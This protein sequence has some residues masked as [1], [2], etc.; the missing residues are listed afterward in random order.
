[1]INQ[2]REVYTGKL[3][4]ELTQLQNGS[5]IRADYKD[6]GIEMYRNMNVKED[7]PLKDV[8][9]TEKSQVKGAEALVLRKRKKEKQRTR[10]MPGLKAQE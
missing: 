5:P 10:S 3:L 2:P 9:D 4:S 8:I 7:L 1:M 6:C